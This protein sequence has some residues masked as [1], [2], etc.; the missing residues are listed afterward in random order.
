MKRGITY[1]T[2][3]AR[4]G[5]RACGS[6]HTQGSSQVARHRACMPQTPGGS[7][8]DGISGGGGFK[9]PGRHHRGL[10]ATRGTASTVERAGPSGPGLP[11]RAFRG[12]GVKSRGQRTPEA[13]RLDPSRL[14]ISSLTFNTLSRRP[15]PADWSWLA[16]RACRGQGA[17]PRGYLLHWADLLGKQQPPEAKAP[18][19]APL[20]PSRF[21]PP[22]RLPSPSGP[23]GCLPLAGQRASRLPSPSGPAGG[24]T[25]AGQRSTR[26]VQGGGA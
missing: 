20:V 5:R 2:C 16:F 12:L 22:S 10:H 6:T 17:P 3:E 11:G 25:V 26:R 23:A 21:A 1:N 15:K 9:L 14:H 4:F 8:G 18:G 24:P 7:A 19:R 13:S